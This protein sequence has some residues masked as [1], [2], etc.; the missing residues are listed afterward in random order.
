MTQPPGFRDARLSKLLTRTC[1]TPRAHTF[2]LIDLPENSK[3]FVEMA[4]E[5]QHRDTGYGKFL[6]Q[7]DPSL[8]L[9]DN[10]SLSSTFG[11]TLSPYLEGSD[12]V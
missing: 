8:P 12:S 2:T 7:H 4:S 3:Y 6:A 9:I 10:G 5:E 11:W 1:R